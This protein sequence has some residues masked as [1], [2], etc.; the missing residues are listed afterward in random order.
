MEQ[1]MQSKKRSSGARPAL[2]A[3]AAILMLLII[4]SAWQQ[5]WLSE[6]R[7]SLTAA[8]LTDSVLVKG[9]V[10]AAIPLLL[11]MISG[12][13]DVPLRGLLRQPFPWL[14]CL[15]ALALS[16]A[17]LHTLR[18][19]NGLMQTHV[20]F[21][22]WMVVLSV[23]AGVYEEIGFR[24]FLFN[25]QDAALGFWPAALLNGLMFTLFHYPGLILGELAGLVSLRT[26][27]IFAMGVLFC[28][29]FRRWKSLTML[30]VV[31]TAWDLM[32]YLFCLA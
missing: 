23:T 28:W 1:N 5:L 25:V 6:L 24:G 29:M 27:L 9:V 4:W 2:F 31:H 26:V 14:P 3:A 30:I 21:D 13:A 22:V 32:S 18:L 15:V 10:W 20:I 11:L 8:L 16:A 7:L 12:R 17:F 19:L